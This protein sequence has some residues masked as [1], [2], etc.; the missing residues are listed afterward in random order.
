MNRH[1]LASYGERIPAEINPE[2]YAS[3]LEMLEHAM[4]RTVSRAASACQ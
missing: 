2:T 4:K 3:V 1:W